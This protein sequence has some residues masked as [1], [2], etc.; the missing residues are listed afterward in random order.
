MILN[1]KEVV[2]N[3]IIIDVR[4]PAVPAEIQIKTNTRGRANYNHSLDVTH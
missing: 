2:I 3:F 4:R 1:G